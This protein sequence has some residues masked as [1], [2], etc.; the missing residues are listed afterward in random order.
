[1][2]E[3]TI[4][5]QAARRL[6]EGRAPR[7]GIGLGA[8]AVAAA[9]AA[10]S[11]RSAT[12]MTTAEL[13]E[14]LDARTSAAGLDERL[15][16]AGARAHG[17]DVDRRAHAGRGARSSPADPARLRRARRGAVAD[18][19]RELPGTRSAVYEGLGG[20]TPPDVRARPGGARALRTS[21][22][23]GPARSPTSCSTG[24]ADRR[25]PGDRAAREAPR[26]RVRTGAR[27]PRWLPQAA[28]RTMV[29]E[30]TVRAGR[31]RPA[32]RC[33]S[34]RS[35]GRVRGRPGDAAHGAR[36]AVRLRLR[37]SATRRPTLRA[38]P[39]RARAA[40][41]R[42]AVERAVRCG[43]AS[44]SNGPASTSCSSAGQRRLR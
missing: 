8:R 35:G 39:R 40:R 17:H 20:E 18:A 23:R 10:R 19:V 3:T 13:V 28:A 34:P 44:A 31:R 24:G 22:R 6:A 27:R 2:A 16:G 9:P 11:G 7:A 12:P 43:P 25:D 26:C 5:L 29:R 37:R 15:D 36:R 30:A 42:R 41:R 4:R 33:R 21:I 14:E 38:L 1:M 32:S